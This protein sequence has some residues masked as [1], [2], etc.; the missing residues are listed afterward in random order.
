MNK[1]EVG[2]TAS[3][4]W[5]LVGIKAV[6]RWERGCVLELKVDKK[7]LNLYGLVHGGCVATLIDAAIGF[8]AHKF[9]P[10]G[11]VCTAIQLN[12]NFIRPAEEGEVLRATSEIIHCGRTTMV[13]VC[14]V[15]DSSG[16]VVAYGSGTGAIRSAAD[17]SVRKSPLG[18]A[19]E[20]LNERWRAD[21]GQFGYRCR[22]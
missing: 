5:Q 1:E 7:N 9:L 20:T 12:V 21:D 8:A 6:D 18:G 22:G 16:R 17:F 10:A 2:V 11:Q 14:R 13:G 19:K 3:P 4:F 15:T